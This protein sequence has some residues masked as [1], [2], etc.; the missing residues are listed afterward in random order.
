[1]ARKR[2][3]ACRENQT[4]TLGGKVL[5]LTGQHEANTENV[6]FG[7][8]GRLVARMTQDDIDALVTSTKPGRL[9][10]ELPQFE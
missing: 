8:R 7:A 4:T 1:M 5:L 9:S 6:R 2:P 3:A 10:A